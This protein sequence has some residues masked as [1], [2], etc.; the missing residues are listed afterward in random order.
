MKK[1]FKILFWFLG[2]LVAVVLLAALSIPLW[3]GPVATSVA[4]SVVPGYTGSD[5]RLERFDL[6]PYTGKLRVVNARLSNPAGYD[7]PVAFSVSTVSVH[8]AM[9][10]LFSK[11]IHV[12]DISVDS[13]YVSY[14]FDKAGSNNFER[15]AAAAAAKGGSGDAS[16]E[17]KDAGGEKDKASDSSGSQVKVLID[18]LAISGTKVK[19]RMI[20]LPIPLPVFTDIGKETNGATFEEVVATV[21]ATIEK[22][23]TGLA[24][25]I[26]AAAGVVGEK[27]AETM[28]NMTNALGNAAD[29]VGAGVGNAVKGGADGAGK[30][31]KNSAAA[32]GKGVGDTVKGGAKAVGDGVKAVGDGVKAVGDGAKGALKKVGSLFGK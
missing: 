32:V 29:G 25:G 7:D 20:T 3:I 18:R 21:W 16:A 14:V 26:G 23:F 22:A 31:V 1:A 30:A 12:Y 10:S 19:Y 17:A 9:S 5:F 24:S 27:A 8:V 11:T 15:I 4:E 2:A 6:N 13:P 28:K